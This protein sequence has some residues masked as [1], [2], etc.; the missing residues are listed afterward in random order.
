M[1]TPAR[2]FLFALVSC[3]WGLACS[4]ADLDL[5]VGV[6][7]VDI[8]PPLGI[9]MAGYYHERGAD[10]VLD[11]LFSKAMVLESQ[12]KRVAFVVVDLLNVTRAITD[13]ARAEIEKATDIPRG[14]V[15]ISATHAHTGPELS[16]RSTH[17][18]D[19]GGR[20]ELAVAY[21]AALPAK[22]AQSVRLA[23]ER[24]LPASL[25]MAKGRCE[26]LTF[27]RRYFMR[28]G[29]VGWN[30]GKMNPQIVMP[31][32]P[33]DP[34]VE[35]L[36]VG[37]PDPA[38]PTPP[39]ATYVHFAMHPD[40]TGGSRLSADWPGA[41]S[42]LLSGYHGT[43]HFTLVANGT[44][45]N[46]NHLDFSW[47][48]PQ[49]GPGEQNRIAAILGAT[50]FQTYKTLKPIAAG[51]LGVRSEIVE[52]SLPEI[53]PAQIEEARKTVAETKDDRGGNFMK[54]VHAYRALEVAGCEGKPNK[55]EV[56]VIALG[57][58]VAWV[59]LPGEAFVELGLAIKKRSPFPQTFVVELA[60]ENLGYI[61]DRRSYAEGNYEPESARCAPGSGEKLVD[62][63]AALLASLHA[64]AGPSTPGAP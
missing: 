27:N 59:S 12:G 16:D 30:P 43:N 32:G 31:A 58:Q 62:V 50:V 55:V 33:T 20:H 40:T 46:L 45:G 24:L 49:G 37:R 9:P 44:C 26:G 15:M 8:T 60:N 22:I 13:Q 11:P 28:D 2:R 51:R 23:Y 42:R 14:H 54:L 56:Q 5:H 36:C 41:L 3:A 25:S 29:S 21:T 1:I 57:T 17:G 35:I 47:A 6:A 4:A 53:S 10:G 39:S 61:P 34:E 18:M 48:W 19:M 52:L 38:D 64:E 7:S 63:A